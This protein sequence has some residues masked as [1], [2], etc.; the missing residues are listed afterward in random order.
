M[1]VIT[2]ASAHHKQP[3][4]LLHSN[5]TSQLHACNALGVHNCQVCTTCLVCIVV[6]YGQSGVCLTLTT[7]AP[8]YHPHQVALAQKWMLQRARLAGKPG[9]VAGQVMESM[10]ASPRPSRPE[11]TDVVNAVYDGADGIVLMQVWKQQ[12]QGLTVQD[13]PCSKQFLISVLTD[14]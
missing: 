4:S 5:F 12:L 3:G 9:L 1:T 11:I 6:A 2:V 7:F 10:A 13:G 14:S 8:I